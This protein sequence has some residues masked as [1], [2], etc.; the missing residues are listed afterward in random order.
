MNGAG[1]SASAICAAA[2]VLRNWSDAVS[3]ARSVSTSRRSSLSPAHASATNA[4][5]SC[6]AR[7]SA[8]RS[9]A[10]TSV[11]RSVI[12]FDAQAA[13]ESQLDDLA[14]T[15][16]GLREGFECAVHRDH[17]DWYF[18]GDQPRL[19][20]RHLVR[21]SAALSRGARARVIDENAAHQA[22]SNADEMRPILPAHRRR[23]RKSEKHF[24]HERGGLKCVTLALAAHVRPR[25]P[26]QLR[27]D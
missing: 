17:I 2:G 19:V 3:W 21:G 14:L 26:V 18:R 24:V 15:R 7:A 10:S 23:L 12:V 27:L 9:I 13:K 5:R 8:A 20:E 1:A 22:C 25:E 16:V 4:G 6:A 11:Q